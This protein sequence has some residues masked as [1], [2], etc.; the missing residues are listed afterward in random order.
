MR[1]MTRERAACGPR[2]GARATRAWAV[3]PPALRRSGSWRLRRAQLHQARRSVC[4]CHALNTTMQL[5]CV[6]SRS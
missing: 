5:V 2:R 6:S 3:A 1:H 4:V